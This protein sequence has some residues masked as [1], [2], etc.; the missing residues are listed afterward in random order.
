MRPVNTRTLLTQASTSICFGECW[1]VDIVET[2][3][4][5]ELTGLDISMFI[6]VST[7]NGRGRPGKMTIQNGNGEMGA[8]WFDP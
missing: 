2:Q 3:W 4:V 5:D 8:R 7:M 6:T 1:F